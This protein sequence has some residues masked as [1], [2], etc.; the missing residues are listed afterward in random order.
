MDADCDGFVDLIGTD[1][2]TGTIDRR[3][4]PDNRGGLRLERVDGG[5]LLHGAR[6]SGLLAA[7]QPGRAR[8]RLLLVLPVPRL[9][10]PRRVVDRRAARR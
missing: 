9:L 3:R 4:L 5:G 1:P 6:D 2:G 8:D 7:A 10:R